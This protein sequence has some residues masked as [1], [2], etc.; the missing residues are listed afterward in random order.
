MSVSHE[1]PYIVLKP[2]SSDPSLCFLSWEL[3]F[4]SGKY[5]LSV[6]TVCSKIR[7]KCTRRLSWCHQTLSRVLQLRTVSL[8]SAVAQI[9]FQLT[10]LCVPTTQQFGTANISLRQKPPRIAVMTV[11]CILF[12]KGLQLVNGSAFRLAQ[13]SS[14][15]AVR[16]MCAAVTC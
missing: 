3:P 4:F 16:D 5:P 10:C 8:A 13:D 7:K 6:S 12:M 15:S 11:S 1:S 9:S 2:E 14:A